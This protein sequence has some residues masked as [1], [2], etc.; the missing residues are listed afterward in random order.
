MATR[1]TPAPPPTLSES[2]PQ[3]LAT[4]HWGLL[5][6]RAMLWNEAFSRTSVFLNVLSAAVVA[7][8]LIA[9]ATEFGDAFALFALVLFP[10]VL[11]LGLATYARLIE[12][13]MGDALHVMAM[14]RLRHG[15]IDVAPELAPYFTSSWHDDVAGINLSYNMGGPM[16]PRWMQVFI[17]TPMV[18]ATVN[19][20]IAAAGAALVA[21]RYGARGGL[22]IVIGSAAFLVL[23]VL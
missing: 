9:D 16:P 19:S 18:V 21:G 6:G 7:L 20:I 8:A 2:A 23:W 15:Y 3:I 13:N 17:T 22:L 14:N 5:S 12:V 11:F 10:L 1:P 4:E